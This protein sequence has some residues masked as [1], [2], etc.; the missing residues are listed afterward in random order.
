MKFKLWDRIKI[1]SSNWPMDSGKEGT[2][3]QIMGKQINLLID[4]NQLCGPFYEDDLELI[5]PARDLAQDALYYPPPEPPKPKPRD[6]CSVCETDIFE[7]DEYFLLLQKEK[8][9]KRGAPLEEIAI[10]CVKCNLL[11]QAQDAHLEHRKTEREAAHKD[12]E[13]EF[14]KGWR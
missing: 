14:R 2:I 7:E 1:K 12:G 4:D 8:E 10:L 5:Y 13:A 11:D 6:V 3:V 9:A